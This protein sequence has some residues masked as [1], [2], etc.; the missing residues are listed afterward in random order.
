MPKNLMYFNSGEEYKVASIGPDLTPINEDH[1]VIEV[2]EEIED[3]RFSVDEDGELVIAYEGQST[4]EALASL[5]A[6][7]QAETAAREAE[8][9]ASRGE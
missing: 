1:F 6:D 7:Q 5:L 3:W 9:V 8:V 4:E 2:P